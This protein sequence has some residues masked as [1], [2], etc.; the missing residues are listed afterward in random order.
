[1]VLRKLTVIAALLPLI[2]ITLTS[3]ELLEGVN[4][5]QEIAVEIEKA[6]DAQCAIE[7][8]VDPSTVPVYDVDYWTTVLPENETRITCVAGNGNWVCNCDDR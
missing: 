3:C 1:M 2:A 4:T 5:R 8:M 6:I 7:V